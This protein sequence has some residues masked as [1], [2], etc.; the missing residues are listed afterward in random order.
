V[1]PIGH[2]CARHVSA[3]EVI[4]QAAEALLCAA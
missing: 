2:P 1:C 4:A 3:R